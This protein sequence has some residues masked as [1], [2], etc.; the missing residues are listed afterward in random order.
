[1]LAELPFVGAE[2]IAEQF[3]PGGTAT[4][5]SALET[6]RRRGLLSEGIS[7]PLRDESGKTRGTLRIYSSLARDAAAFAA[8]GHDAPAMRLVVIARRLERR[9]DAVMIADALAKVGASIAPERRTIAVMIAGAAGEPSVAKQL[10]T[11]AEAVARAREK[12]PKA[13]QVALGHVASMKQPMAS[14]VLLD[15]AVVSLPQGKLPALADEGVGTPV[16][17]RWADLGRGV[18]MTAEPA[19]DVPS[20]A[21][22]PIYPFERRGGGHTTIPSAV[23][24]GVPTMRRSG[25]T[26]I[27]G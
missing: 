11:C 9:R 26:K 17:I 1:M 16:A 18:W 6:L 15:G 27:A 14:I 8:A 2:E 20:S 22:G 21:A 24:A 13:W 10:A 3:R 7:R 12:A 23:L 25:R 19:I 5:K 4:V